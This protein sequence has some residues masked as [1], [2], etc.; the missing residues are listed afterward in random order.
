MNSVVRILPHLLIVVIKQEIKQNTLTVRTVETMEYIKNARSLLIS[1]S[2]NGKLIASS[3]SIWFLM[4]TY[5]HH[6]KPVHTGIK[7]IISV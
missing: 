3:F 4:S 2:S 6:R 7:G 1:T 5:V